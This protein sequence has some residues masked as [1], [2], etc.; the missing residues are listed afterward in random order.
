MCMHCTMKE[1]E[2]EVR[3]RQ[4]TELKSPY[5]KES[6]V[7]AEHNGKSLEQLS[8]KRWYELSYIL[9]ISSD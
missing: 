9:E 1:V 6:L 8:R 5:R 2:D 4:Q 7:L 3:V